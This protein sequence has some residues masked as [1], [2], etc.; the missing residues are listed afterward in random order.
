MC[1]V[2][3]S[4]G[5]PEAVAATMKTLPAEMSC[6]ARRTVTARVHNRG[7]TAWSDSSP[8]TLRANDDARVL[9]SPRVIV[10]TGHGTAGLVRFVQA[11]AH[12]PKH[13]DVALA[14][15]AAPPREDRDRVGP[16]A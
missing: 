2:A 13:V 4:A 1:A 16:F 14:V 8:M 12:R 6:G 5:T 7:R 15:L 3:G 10:R 9:G 11:R